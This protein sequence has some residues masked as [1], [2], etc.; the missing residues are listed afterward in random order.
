MCIRDSGEGELESEIPATLLPMMS[1]HFKEHMAVLSA[2]NTLLKSWAAGQEAGAELPRA[3]GMTPFQLGNCTGQII[4]RPFSLLRLQAAMDV[5]ASLNETQRAKA[6]EL[7][8][9]TGGEALIDFEMGARL[10]RANYK[11]VLEG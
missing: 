8:H 5:Y 11:L 9:A 6:D 4:A 2:T 1:R 3:F 7:L 10:T